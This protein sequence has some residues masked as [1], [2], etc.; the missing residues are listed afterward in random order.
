M[1]PG[2]G[3]TTLLT[4]M[5]TFLT[6]LTLARSPSVPGAAPPLW[7]EPLE[8]VPAPGEGDAG[9][10]VGPT[11]VLGAF[12]AGGIASRP[13]E[14]FWRRDHVD[15]WFRGKKATDCLSAEPAIRAALVDKRNWAMSSL[16]I[17][18]SGEWR[19]MQPLERDEQGFT[20]VA[21]YWFETFS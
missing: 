9:T 6:G 18:D 8:G 7:L 16:T 1:S 17:I 5:R 3:D 19:P 13:Y 11:L 4:S 20:Y 12:I 21:A 15:L 2:G 14:S 10:T